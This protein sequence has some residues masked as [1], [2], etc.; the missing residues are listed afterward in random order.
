MI[1]LYM[2]TLNVRSCVW[3]FSGGTAVTVYG[4]HLNAVAEIN[5]TLTVVI[6]RFDRDINTTSTESYRTVEV[7]TY[8]YNIH[9]VLEITL[10]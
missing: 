10:L 5:I 4:S 9:V 7:M 3:I 8:L 6:T 2:Q 1:T